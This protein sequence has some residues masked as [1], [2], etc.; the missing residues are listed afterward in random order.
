MSGQECM[1]TTFAQAGSDFQIQYVM[2][3]GAPWFKAKEVAKLLGYSNT[4]EAIR[5]HV[6]DKHRQKM[7][8]LVKSETLTIDYHTRNSIFIN[9]PGL[10][11]LILKSH[12]E[13]ALAFQDWVTEEVLPSIRKP[14]RTP[15]PL[16]N[17]P[18][19]H[20]L[21]HQPYRN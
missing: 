13:Q 4:A 7:G 1:I 14:A 16:S 3:D 8:E 20:R 15:S 19:L 2:V 21:S 10:Y 17:R 11:S 18:Y 6:R 9:E 12:Q 5:E